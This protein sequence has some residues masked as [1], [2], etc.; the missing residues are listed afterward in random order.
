MVTLFYKLLSWVRLF[1]KFAVVS[2][3]IAMALLFSFTVLIRE[4]PGNYASD[5]TWIEEAVRMLNIY[6]VFMGL[7]L[8]LERGKHVSISTLRD[9]LPM[10][11][12]NYLK[13]TIDFVGFLFAIYLCTLSYKLMVFVDST[14]Q[15]SPTLGVSMSLIY[16][17]PVIGFSLLALRY[18]ISFFKIID[19]F[20]E[21]ET[22]DN[23]DDNQQEVLK[24]QPEDQNKKVEKEL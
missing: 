5:F 11:Y 8:A 19:R 17:A 12:S 9:M 10:P 21:F 2:I 22:Q 6:L 24:N 1:E 3:F 23:G 7:G 13:K 14:G 20:S 15:I 4:V 16:L 18:F